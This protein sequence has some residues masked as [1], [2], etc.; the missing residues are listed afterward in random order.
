MN[1]YT[2]LRW[3][4]SGAAGA[5]RSV[6]GAGRTE[7][8]AG[9]AV[10]VEV[11][12]LRSGARREIFLHGPGDV[13]GLNPA[14]VIRRFPEPDSP[15]VGT[16]VFA[17]V[18]F[19]DP[20]LPWRYTPFGERTAP[21]ADGRAPL[22]HGTLR[23]WL[24]LIV[25][26]L[27]TG[28]SFGLT[29]GSPLP[30]LRISDR[31]GEELP[32]P[33]ELHAWAHVQVIGD[34]PG[35]AAEI[36]GMFDT[37]PR[38]TLSRLVA[39][40]LLDSGTPYLACVVP[41]FEAGRQAGLG[42]EVT[43]GPDDL[44]WAPGATEAVLPVYDS[45]TFATGPEGEFKQLVRR[46][47]PV[48]LDEIV[49]A[50]GIPLVGR[51]PMDTGSPGFGLPPGT[52]ADLFGALRLEGDD[53]AAGADGG[54]AD[55]LLAA[56]NVTDAVA[57]P[58]YGRWHAA[59]PV[60]VPNPD[61]P[62]WLSALNLHPGLRVAAGMGAEVVRARQEE[63]MAAAWEQAGEILKA[64][65]LLRQAEL[66]VAAAARLHLRHL[67]PLPDV[68]ALEFAGPALSRLRSTADPARTPAG[69]IDEH[70]LP[71]VC[72]SG[73]WIRLVRRRGPLIR[74]VERR[75]DDTRYDPADITAALARGD[76]QAPPP[77]PAPA[78]LVTPDEVVG[79]LRAGVPAGRAQDRA[80]LADLLDTLRERGTTAPC[81]P[82]PLDVIAAD[83][84]DRLHPATTIPRRVGARL[85][86][87]A[88][89][90][91]ADRIDP[92]M[93]APRIT[94][95]MARFLA[96][97]GQDWILPGL[98]HVP[99]ET[100]AGVVA[101]QMFVE[102]FLTGMN[103]EMSR[104]LLW[105]GYPTDQRGTVFRHFFDPGS[106]P[107]PSPGDITEIHTWGSGPLG[108]HA[109]RAGPADRFVLVI[110]GELVRRFPRVAVFMVKAMLKDG[111]RVPAPVDATAELPVFS[112]GLEPDAVFFGFEVSAA[113]AAGDPGHYV[114][115][116]EQPTEP[117]FGLGAVSGETSD[118]RYT[119]WAGLGRP[120]VATTAGG[121]L[122]LTATTTPGFLSRIPG[123]PPEWDGRSDS[124]AAILLRRPFRLLVH[125]SD[126]LPRRRA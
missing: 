45:W 85:R 108:A 64:N 80:A 92:I 9:F 101:N 62:A 43:A 110:R 22:R 31:A 5:I 52:V 114:V 68:R 27:R 67:M 76:R 13:I 103:H 42:E 36:T 115:F 23:P 72:L 88:G 97:Q 124:L 58:V 105:R 113:E 74:R 84:R 87:P 77:D 8:R 111:R 119:T 81:R 3:L 121:Y 7:R 126:I 44:A 15:A 20:D 14:Q 125:G 123:M 4:R 40:R 50:D 82:T 33:D 54:L 90:R 122:D 60:G 6:E 96:E 89:S 12:G 32:P 61:W 53:P 49:D 86:L 30:V 56:V 94:A 65:Q 2:F 117:C 11:Q 35:T 48:R 19:D 37:E 104:E 106:A 98:A 28:V 26:R 51:R 79:A 63:F 38:R 39:P 95:P 71:R 34:L 109:A 17:H 118:G 69:V 100:V 70:C 99:A 93:V 107:G 10:D 112:G 41:V 25:V 73:Q 46:L 59:A 18:E 1:R 55:A 83:A 29:P 75:H 57:P 78:A 91:S 16:D 120:D 102:A 66:A 21:D 47:K 116:Q 24:C